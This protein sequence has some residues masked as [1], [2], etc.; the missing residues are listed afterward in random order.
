[1]K[2]KLSNAAKIRAALAAGDKAKN[3]SQRLK[4]PI[5]TVYTINWKM[6]NGKTIKRKIPFVIDTIEPV[7]KQT[8]LADFIRE[9]VKNLEYDINRLDNIRSFL[10]LR[11]QQL[12]QNGK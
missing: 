12:E 4:V 11:L 3:I 5:S 10:A 9:E 1:M 8:P 7:K 6:K 2:T